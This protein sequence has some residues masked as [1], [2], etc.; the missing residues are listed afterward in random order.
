MV[1]AGTP[2]RSPRMAIFLPRSSIRY[3][4]IT[5]GSDCSHLLRN[6]LFPDLLEFVIPECL[7]RESR[8][9]PEWTPIKTFGGDGCGI[10]LIA[11]S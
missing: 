1:W 2:S 9:D 5:A 6:E 7:Y 4:S 11:R 10:N 8:Q 3:L